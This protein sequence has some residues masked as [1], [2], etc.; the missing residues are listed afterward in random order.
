MKEKMEE[1][2]EGE[3]KARIETN[4][5]RLLQAFRYMT[6]SQMFQKVEYGLPAKI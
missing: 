1:E 2:K 3:D 4:R 6:H 5:K